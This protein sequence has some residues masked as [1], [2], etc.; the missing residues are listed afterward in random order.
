MLREVSG[1]NVSRARNAG[2]VA[3]IHVVLA[4]PYFSRMT[5]PTRNNQTARLLQ[6]GV[7]AMPAADVLAAAI[8][9]FATD[10]GVYSA[11]PEKQGPTHVVLRGQGGE[12]IVIGVRDVPGGTGVTGSSYLFDQQIAQFIAGLPP[13]AAVA[14]VAPV[15]DAVALPAGEGAV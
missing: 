11:F 13:A 14:A 9:F 2:P 15:E 8:R 5:S 6:E 4:L 1:T 3:P 12:E 7:T 10:S